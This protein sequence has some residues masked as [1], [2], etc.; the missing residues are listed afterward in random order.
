MIKRIKEYL[1]AYR[2]KKAVK[3]ANNIAQ[4][5]KITCYVL[6]FNKKLWVVPKRSIKKLIQQRR[7]KAG[8]TIHDIEKI[9]L[10]IA[11]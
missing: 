5:F 2:Y 7:F 1:W 8:T 10:H 4:D 3:K 11:K 9:A 6:Y